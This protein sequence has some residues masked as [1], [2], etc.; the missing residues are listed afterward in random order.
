M[1]GI[2]PWI[3]IH[4]TGEVTKE[5]AQN[6]DDDF[7]N[8]FEA[9]NFSETT[10][11]MAHMLQD[12]DRPFKRIFDHLKKNYPSS[13]VLHKGLEG[14]HNDDTP[15]VT[16]WFYKQYQQ[17]L[18]SDFNRQLVVDEADEAINLEGEENE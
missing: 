16:S 2:L 7:W 6:L 10:F 11:I 9:A 8:K 5:S 13:K 18:I 17:L 1:I 15:G 4:I 14:R 3:L 12:T